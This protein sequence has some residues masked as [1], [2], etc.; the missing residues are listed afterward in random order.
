M[1]RVVESS[2][3]RTSDV[4][5]HGFSGPGGFGAE[6]VSGFQ[7]WIPENERAWTSL[8]AFRPGDIIYTNLCTETVTICHGGSDF[9]EAKNQD[10]ELWNFRGLSFFFGGGALTKSRWNSPR[11]ELMVF[12]P[13]DG[14]DPFCQRFFATSHYCTS[15]TT[16][17]LEGQIYGCFQK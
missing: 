5:T 1:C 4:S 13:I 16:C 2:L 15:S 10:F 6:V 11:I 9:L 14:G 8:R 12:S 17:S 7:F 3:S